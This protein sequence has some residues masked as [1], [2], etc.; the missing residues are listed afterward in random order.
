MTEHLHAQVL[1][2]IAQGLSKEIECRCE[3]WPDSQ[4]WQPLLGNTSEHLGT[5]IK[6]EWDCRYEFR[7]KPRT[8]KIGSREVEA[9][10]L[11]PDEGQRAWFTNSRGKPQ[12]SDFDPESLLHRERAAGGRYYASEAAAV[13]A[14]EAVSALLRGESC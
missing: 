14:H 1:R 2:W 12:W 7:L 9:P 8:V 5:L 6:E 13:A 10:V 4:N 3:S 11:E